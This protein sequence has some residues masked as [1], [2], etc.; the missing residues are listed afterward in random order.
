MNQTDWIGAAPFIQQGFIGPKRRRQAV[1]DE[2][3]A[4]RAE[5]RDLTSRPPPWLNSAGIQATREWV[6]RQKAAAKLMNSERASV[7]QLQSAVSS[8]R[9][10][11]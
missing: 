7:Q 2:K 6:A 5:L 3:E 4:L 8:M 9:R 1:H 11:P 10:E